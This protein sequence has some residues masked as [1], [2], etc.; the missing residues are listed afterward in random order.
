MVLSRLTCQAPSINVSYHSVCQVPS[1][2][3]KSTVADVPNL[4]SSNCTPPKSDQYGQSLQPEKKNSAIFCRNYHH[5]LVESDQCSETTKLFIYILQ[6]NASK[7]DVQPRCSAGIEH[8]QNAANN[9]PTQNLPTRLPNVS[10][11]ACIWTT[12]TCQT[13]NDCRSFNASVSI[14]Y[15]AAILYRT[16]TWV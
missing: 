5:L 9:P 16:L 11:I 3:A 2:S 14:F 15:A 1:D 13:E 7:I 4:V 6:C 12:S 8:Q 10:M